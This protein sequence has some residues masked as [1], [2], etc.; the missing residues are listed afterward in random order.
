MTDFKPVTR[1]EAIFLLGGAAAL[2]TL[3]RVTGAATARLNDREAALPYMKGMILFAITPM[4]LR[5]GKAEIDYDGMSRNMQ[6]FAGQPEPYLIT[7]CGGTG[8]FYDL[9]T[10][11]HNRIIAAAAAEKGDRILL[12]GV[13]GDETREAVKLAQATEKAGADALVIMPS[14]VI[15]KQGDEALLSHYQE[16]ANAVSVGVLPYRRP[17][18]PFGMDMI[19]RLMETPNVIGLKDG[20]G[21][22]TFIRKVYLKT[23]GLLPIFPA[24][25]R[26]TPFLHLAGAK[27]YTSGHA[28]FTPNHSA[29]IWQLCE[30]GK[31]QEAMKLGDYF[32]RLDDL[33]ARYGNILL[34][35]GLELRGLAGGPLRKGP[36]R[37][38]D[39]GREA[40]KSVLADLGVL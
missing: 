14:E 2:A 25:E 5:A 3:T 35:A 7:V 12:A 24:A 18:N 10:E 28:N 20:I 19:L 17:V 8:E 26:S 37:M 15:A 6:F 16:I 29:R 33:R 34:K 40:L 39:E 4:Q 9:R 38:P 36:E 11:E 13:G 31:Y 32:I 1:R 21:D 23:E 30:E 22:L 27:G